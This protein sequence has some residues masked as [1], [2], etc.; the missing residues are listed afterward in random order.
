MS[1]LDLWSVGSGGKLSADKMAPAAKS[2]P[3]Y[4]PTDLAVRL[5]MLEDAQNSDGRKAI[6][7]VMANRAAAAKGDLLGVL[8]APK[9]FEPWAT[10]QKELAAIDPNSD[11]YKA[12][13]ADV[14]PVLQG[15]VPN[16]VGQAI[17]FYSPESQAAEAG[18]GQH[19]A[20]PGFDDGNGVR[21]GG[22]LFFGTPA[23]AAPAASGDAP[24]PFDLFAHGGGK[25]QPLAG[26]TAADGADMTAN[27]AP[28][29]KVVNG[30]VVFGDNG[31]EVPAEQVKLLHSLVESGRLK[32]DGTID[33]HT[34]HMQRDP[35]D[36]FS[37]GDFYISAPV[38][39]KTPEESQGPKLMGGPQ[40]DSFGGGLAQGAEDVGLTIANAAS[41]LPG[42][43]DS[44]LQ[45]FLHSQQQVYD[46]THAHG[47][48][49]SGLG[50]F[51][52]QVAASAPIMAAAEVP[53]VAGLSKL[54]PVGEFIAGKGVGGLATRAGSLAARGALE[55][56][57]G[58]GLISSA[59]DEPVGE[60]IAG[61]ALGG[62]LLGP[63]LHGL[64][65]AGKG[66]A[67]GLARFLEPFTD[68]GANKAADRTIRD[69]A[70][71]GGGLGPMDLTEHVPGAP[72][73]TLA[74]ATGNPALAQLQRNLREH[75][76][77]Q[78]AF[79]EH[80]DANNAA[81]QAVTLDA[82]GD[83]ATVADLARQRAALVDAHRAHVFGGAGEADAAPVVSTIDAAL[84]SAEAAHPDVAPALNKVR[85]ALVTD[86]ADGHTP[87]EAAAF[88]RAAGQHFGA[89]GPAWTPD[90]M[91]AAKRKLS[92]E[93]EDIAGSTNISAE[94]AEQL[95][96]NLRSVVHDASQVIEE[97]KLKPLQNL[98]AQIESTIQDGQIS[99]ASY[100]ALIRRNGPLDILA[101]NG[102]GAM[103]HYAG[104]MREHLDDA[105]EN[106]MASDFPGDR[107]P[108][109]PKPYDAAAAADAA[110]L[111]GKA[112]P[113]P[114]AAPVLDETD[115]ALNLIRARKEARS[116]RGPSLSDMLIKNGGL[117]DEGGELGD[118]GRADYGKTGGLLQRGKGKTINEA[119]E[120]AH[121][122]GYIGK[123]GSSER[124]SPEEFLAA[125]RQD[126]DARQGTGERVF[127][128]GPTA[129]DA[130][131][132]HADELEEMLHE[133][134]LD[135]HTTPNGR[136]RQKMDE[137]FGT[138]GATPPPAG[139]AAPAP[140]PGP[141]VVPG[142]VHEATGLPLN[143]DGTVTV[144]HHTS[145]EA[146]AKIRESGQLTSGGEPDVYVTSQRETGTGYG[147]AVVPIRVKPESL[148]LD[149]EFSNGR[150]DFRMNA[151]RP[152]GSVPVQIGE[153]AAAGGA[154]ASGLS[155][156]DEAANAARGKAALDRL[157][158]TRLGYKNLKTAEAALR[159][160]GPD[161]VVT[162]RAL[163]NAVRQ[164]FSS[165][166]YKGG[167]PL[168]DVAADAM[169]A[170]EG[171][172][173]TFERNPAQLFAHRENLSTA[174]DK[175]S[176]AGETDDAARAAAAKLT[177][178]R[179]AMDAALDAST[180]GYARYREIADSTAEPIEAQ[181]YLQ[182]LPLSTNG[183]KG[184][185]VTLNLVN[186]A[187]DRIDKARSLPG[188]HPAKAIHPHTLMQL[189]ALQADLEREANRDLGKAKGSPT[190]QLA[191]S[192]VQ[193]AGNGVP[194][195]LVQDAAS[196]VPVIGRHVAG[197]IQ[198]QSDVANT[199]VLRALANRMVHPET[200]PALPPAKAGSRVARVM[201]QVGATLPGVSGGVLGSRLF[202]K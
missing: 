64:I 94:H 51:T 73:P 96:H 5:A 154:P 115:Q 52:G 4:D 194:S 131:N 165:F 25:G 67:Q 19:P 90:V 149:D 167:G 184:G 134:G 17:N 183:A 43:E 3:Q 16:P 142:A 57:G 171:R 1:G 7:G 180:P 151:G 76:K 79:T 18:D 20:K 63:A 48:S 169:R 116:G 106:T 8:T 193:M 80:D 62:A 66:G 15:K 111:A 82:Q 120:L 46:A 26:V 139:A 45:N 109:T 190:Y 137:Y 56:A 27:A 29:I 92:A 185:T 105:L 197:A 174:I 177:E 126:M 156:E 153:D 128:Q 99:G 187:I 118:L 175:L 81:R 143:A 138:S 31:Q 40:S 101:R 36:T 140:K 10:K 50:R 164:N 14:I 60:Q 84:A 145:P 110:E 53:A 199:R 152:G 83:P 47:L 133:M 39:G 148:S 107:I 97:G 13:A 132:A 98:V 61:G 65:A 182:S 163:Y 170:I 2:Q 6:A 49:G 178:V 125:L 196:R 147:D 130:I 30:K 172:T 9:A 166:A 72:G 71:L 189:R 24:A 85:N 12:A 103:R 68:K 144:Y 93:F 102:D 74:E 33:G 77:V 100:K 89:D 121:D 87:A 75:Y 155:P 112:P 161:G 11:A 78:G 186:R 135:P 91:D 195:A 34:V 32:S 192:A 42:A 122:L 198:T 136:I 58:A 202:G 179:D 127:S 146:A 70:D 124:P 181:R 54:G 28:T 119:I 113:A 41:N 176:K 69:V 150:R 129:N 157:R 55:G 158:A 159:T 117:R 162:P 95:G 38:A 200:M 104:Q 123:P 173:A 168:G 191:T 108:V 88:M 160:A 188:P 59:S 22:N 44:G 86:P 23:A 114:A 201:D 141:A 37:P 21:I 35:S